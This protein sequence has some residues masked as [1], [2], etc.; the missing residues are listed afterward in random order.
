MIIV[1]KGNVEKAFEE[2]LIRTFECEAC[3]TIFKANSSEYTKEFK[4]YFVLYH[5]NCPICGCGCYDYRDYRN[6]KLTED[7]VFEL[8]DK[9]FEYELAVEQA[10]KNRHNHENTKIGFVERFRKLFQNRK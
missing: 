7:K 3:G 6:N 2:E 1:K 9:E 10:V 4:R 8:M 5:S